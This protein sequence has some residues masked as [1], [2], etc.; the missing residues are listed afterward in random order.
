MY[1]I[2]VIIYYVKHMVKIH[3]GICIELYP[4]ILNLVSTFVW[5]RL[6][7]KALWYS[8]HFPVVGSYDLCESFFNII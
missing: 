8:P 3:F 2:L 6:Y 7:V 5:C 4:F 1:K